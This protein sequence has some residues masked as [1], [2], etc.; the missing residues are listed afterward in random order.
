MKKLYVGGLALL[1]SAT[2]I[3]C[4]QTVT[5]VTFE[6]YYL[7]D[8]EDGLFIEEFIEVGI[9][10]NTINKKT[11]EKILETM[12]NKSV[13]TNL[14]VSNIQ[15][16]EIATAKEK[17]GKIEVTIDKEYSD[18]KSSDITLT[19]TSIFKECVRLQQEMVSMQV[20]ATNNYLMETISGFS[21]EDREL[22]E[23]YL[24]KLTTAFLKIEP[25]GIDQIINKS[26]VV[27]DEKVTKAVDL[28]IS[29][30]ETLGALGDSARQYQKSKS[31]EDL[32]K[33]KS[34][35]LQFNRHIATYQLQ[36]NSLDGNDSS[37]TE[38][39]TN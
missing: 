10:D 24:S 15:G 37:L 30:N 14:T 7:K 13:D 21:T 8:S 16:T 22:T 2:L 18:S 29:T 38:Q 9:K 32:N 4:S 20:M 35:I 33:F 5:E 34:N 27:T 12:E 28:V 19:D 11:V 6:N 26:K 31:K 17:N 39:M 36:V 1:M 25:L 3:G 23:E